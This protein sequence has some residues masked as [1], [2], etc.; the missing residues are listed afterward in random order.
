MVVDVA[1]AVS[2][3]G[4]LIAVALADGN[5]TRFLDTSLS[6]SVVALVTPVRD[7]DGAF[8]T[9]FIPLLVASAT[10]RDGDASSN[11]AAYSPPMFAIAATS[12][13]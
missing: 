6:T 1:V 3:P 11:L 4:I 7:A 12:L 2:F 8:P 13:G 9:S 10:I 5:R